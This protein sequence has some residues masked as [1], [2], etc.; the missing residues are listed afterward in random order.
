MRAPRLTP[1]GCTRVTP[2]V[3]EGKRGHDADRRVERER[4]EQECDEGVHGEP[5]DA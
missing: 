1:A 2:N 3:D 5:P 4:V